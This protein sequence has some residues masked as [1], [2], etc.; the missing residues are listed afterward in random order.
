MKE[1]K[2]WD[3]YEIKARYIPV[4]LAVVPLV[5]FLILFVGDFFWKEL[6]ENIKWMLVIADI[7]LSLIVVL[8]LTQ[9][10]TSLGKHWI[11][12]SVFG[13][14]GEQFPTTNML[15]Y[16]GALISRER[17]DQIRNKIMQS[18]SCVFSSEA[19]ERS[20]QT[21]ARFQ[22][23]EAVGHVRSFVGK[24]EMTIHYNIRYGFV[25]N[26]I[27]GILWGVIGSAL[28]AWYY[29]SAN[30]WKLA[31]LFIIYS[32]IFIIMFALK[33]IILNRLAFAYADSLFNDFLNNSKGAK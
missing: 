26:F 27:A 17:K 14:G 18:F 29:W 19:E 1:I 9:F 23:R 33:S 20:S 8:A 30:Q 5:H 32:A 24:G 28:C 13:K 4:F 21:N 12:E 16:E 7:S 25:R 2:S 11:E 3:E 15:L 6:I 31:S 22:A 10:Q